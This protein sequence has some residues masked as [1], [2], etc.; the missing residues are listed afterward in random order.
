MAA[1]ARSPIADAAQKICW[2]ASFP[3]SGNTW[4]RILLSNLLNRK[5][6]VEEEGVSINL[7]GSISS[8]RVQFDNL[9]WLASSDLTDDEIDLLRPDAYRAIA[10]QAEVQLYTKVH[11]AYHRNGNGDHIFPADCSYGAIYL[12]RHPYDVAISYA[13]HQGH[14]DF[15]KI[16]DQMVSENHDMAGGKKTQLRQRTMGWGGHY[17]SW[18]EQHEIPL[19][20]VRYEDMIADTAAC[21]ESMVDFLRLDEITRDKIEHAVSESSFEKLQAKEEKAG[22]GERAEKAQRFFRSGRAGEGEERLDPELKK[23]LREAN[24]DLMEEL[25]YC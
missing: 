25:G 17:R 14:Q 2:L 10:D 21:L 11:D 20:T 23:I 12:V 7:A 13:Y 6:E 3:K 1:M 22:F 5:D 15:A 16:V 9:T 8:N 19:L 4:T 24:S 18:H